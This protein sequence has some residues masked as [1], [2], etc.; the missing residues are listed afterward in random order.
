MISDNDKTKDNNNNNNLSCNSSGKIFNINLLY[1][2][3]KSKNA[4][5]K[6]KKNNKLL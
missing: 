3:Y 2:I 5:M 4:L 6:I 1:Y